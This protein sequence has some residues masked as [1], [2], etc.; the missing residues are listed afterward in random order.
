M[1]LRD[2]FFFL[3]LLVGILLGV[4]LLSGDLTQNGALS[5]LIYAA[6]V[7]TIRAV[8]ETRAHPESNDG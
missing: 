5:A 4:R 8:R 7:T 1:L 3:L 6:M 2:G